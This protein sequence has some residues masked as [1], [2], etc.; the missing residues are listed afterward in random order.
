MFKQILL[1]TAI[2]A[3]FAFA[4]EREKEEGAIE[5]L[6]R[7]ASYVIAKNLLVEKIKNDINTFN[8]VFKKELILAGFK[9]SEEYGHYNPFLNDL[10]IKEGILLSSNF[11]WV[12]FPNEQVSVGHF[13]VSDFNASDFVCLR[14]LVFLGMKVKPYAIQLR[15]P[16]PN[17]EVSKELYYYSILKIGDLEFPPVKSN[18]PEIDLSKN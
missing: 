17:G 12:K 13:E 6:G 3:N 7:A 18:Y 4:M 16:D 9:N 10:V 15:V 14:G 11:C 5:I 8:Q 2:C 1:A